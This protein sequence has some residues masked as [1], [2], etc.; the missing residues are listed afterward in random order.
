MPRDEPA[1]S[2]RNLYTHNV[3]TILKNA[4][5]LFAANRIHGE[6][7]HDAQSGSRLHRMERSC[8]S[9][10]VVSRQGTHYPLLSL[11]GC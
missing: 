1:N 6:L 2:V 11:T 8:A 10:R 4:S 9:G 5:R 7:R 3:L